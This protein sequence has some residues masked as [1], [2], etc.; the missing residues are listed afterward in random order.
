MPRVSIYRIVTIVIA[1]LLVACA[2]P[3]IVQLSPDT[4]MLMREDHAGIFGSMAKL[5]AGVIRD[6]NAFAA[7]Q[8]KIVIPI[9]TNENPVGI[10]G[11]W[12]R[13]E[14]QFRLVDPNDPDAKS[15]PMERRPDVIT[16]NTEIIDGEIRIKSESDVDD[17]LYAELLKLD[18]LRQRGILTD[19]EFDAQKKKLLESN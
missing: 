7:S 2:N 3:G 11:D 4:Y 16:K 12:A 5:K 1:L 6:A 14:Y 10:M 17:D 15:T 13:F 9:T 19:E 18:D 8:G